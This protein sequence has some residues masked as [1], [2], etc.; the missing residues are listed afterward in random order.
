[1]NKAPALAG[2]RARVASIRASLVDV[3]EGGMRL[4]VP[5]PDVVSAFSV[6]EE[7]QYGMASVTELRL[8]VLHVTF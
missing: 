2:R 8:P 4:G 1:M 7:R 6:R 5:V 3:R